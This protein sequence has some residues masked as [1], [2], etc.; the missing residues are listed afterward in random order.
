MFGILNFLGLIAFVLETN[1]FDSQFSGRPKIKDTV[2]ILIRVQLIKIFA[3]L[4]FG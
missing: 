4:N 2:A 3:L 1:F